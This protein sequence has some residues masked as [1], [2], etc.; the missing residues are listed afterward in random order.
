LAARLRRRS[1][2]AVANAEISKEKENAQTRSRFARSG[3]GEISR[4]QH[5]HIEEQLAGDRQQVL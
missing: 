1:K 5:A 4:S 3:A 2:E